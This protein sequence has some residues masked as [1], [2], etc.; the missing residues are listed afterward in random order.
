MD[1]GL[2][3]KRVLVTAASQGLGYATAK[4]FAKEGAHVIIS[5]RNPEKLEQ[6]AI[7]MREETGNSNVQPI[8]CD[9]S[10]AADIDRLFAEIGP[11]GVDILVNNAGGPRPGDFLA[12]DDADWQ[13]A[14]ELSLLS[15]IRVTR[16]AIPRMQKKQWG[17]ILNFTS[18]S[19]KQPIENLILSNTLRTAVLGLTKS[20]SIELAKDNILVNAIG[21]GRVAT[22]RVEQLDQARAAKTGQSIAEIQRE[23]YDAIPLGRYGNV[24]EFA[25]AAVYLASPAN[26]YITGQALLVDGGMVRAL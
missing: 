26:G 15:V 8:A 22:Q 20:L 19:M 3:E 11:D 4:L 7:R 5:S 2:A 9:V 12:V 1:L 17:R 10:R 25:S 13:A 21:P 24:D 14:F 16:F 6:A 23:W 18:T